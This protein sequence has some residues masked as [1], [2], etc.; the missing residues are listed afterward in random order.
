MSYQ[1]LNADALAGLRT[2]EDASIQ[3]CVTSPP[4]WGLR[5]Y[6]VKGQ[7][8]LER[9]PEEYV[10]HLVAVFREVRRVLREDGTL[11]L[12]LGDSYAAQG[13]G[14]SP[15]IY[16]DKRNSAATWQA[17]RTPTAGL[18]PKDLIGIPWR[19]AFALQADGWY[20]RSDVVWAKTNTMPESV[21]DRP[22]KGHEYLFLLAKSQRYFYDAAA[23]KEPTAAD[24]EARYR[25][26]HSGYDP[27]GQSAHSGLCGP[28]Q[29]TRIGREGV[30]SRPLLRNKRS[31]WSI[32][33]QPYK[34]A[35][36]ATFPEK[37]VE[38]CLLAGSAEGDTVLDPFAGSG[39]V[40]AVCARRH[41]HFVGVELSAAYCKLVR[42]RISAATPLSLAAA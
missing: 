15:G 9:T 33:T 11:W 32:A 30:N 20:L 13:G 34:G 18:K 22:T 27:P 6:K 29:N 2:L 14:K 21:K 28:R 17:P 5:D 7:L 3:C 1:L 19:V 38:P 31:V 41:R 35:H 37:L 40:G 4:Y 42:A 10:S 39:T 24:T 12:N 25:R 8:G 36:F 16:T 23:I 26:A